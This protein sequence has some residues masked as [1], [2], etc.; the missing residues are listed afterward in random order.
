MPSTSVKSGMPL[1]RVRLAAVI[2]LS[3]ACRML[4]ESISSTEEMD[5]HVSAQT[6]GLADGHSPF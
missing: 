6:V 2:A 5:L 3:V 1:C 4:M